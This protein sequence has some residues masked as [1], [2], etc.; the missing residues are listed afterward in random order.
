M[1]FI[2]GTLLAG[3]IV[4]S[5]IAQP[6]AAPPVAIRAAE[7]RFRSGAMGQLAPSF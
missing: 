4:S 3:L 1:R 6:P 5:A 7:A 2:A